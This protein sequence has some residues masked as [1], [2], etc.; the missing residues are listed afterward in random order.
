MYYYAK[1]SQYYHKG[2]Q[3]GNHNITPLSKSRISLKS[4]R[5]NTA[6]WRFLSTPATGSPVNPVLEF[7]GKKTA[8]LKRDGRLAVRLDNIDEETKGPLAEAEFVMIVELQGKMVERVYAVPVDNVEEIVFKGR[9]TRADEL[10][11]AKSKED[12]IKSFGAVNFW[13]GGSSEK[14]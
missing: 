12:V 4:S 14:K 8:L 7:D 13:T 11:L 5:T 2:P 1:Q 6:N 3:N 9:Q 10:V